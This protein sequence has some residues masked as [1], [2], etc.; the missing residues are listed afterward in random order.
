MNFFQPLKTY[1]VL[2]VPSV[3]CFHNTWILLLVELLLFTHRVQFDIVSKYWQIWKVYILTNQVSF[4]CAF[5]LWL[6][7]SALGFTLWLSSL[8]HASFIIADIFVCCATISFLRWSPTV[9]VYRCRSSNL[10]IRHCWASLWFYCDL[11]TVQLC[12]IYKVVFCFRLTVVI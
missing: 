1:E 7:Y 10:Y 8:K 6:S 12:R 4:L 3:D 9:G 2:I 11:F 5:M